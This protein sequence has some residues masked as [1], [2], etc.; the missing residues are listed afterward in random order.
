MGPCSSAD[1]VR[2]ARGLA[3]CA[4][5]GAS[6]DL[7]CARV[8]TP[9][10]TVPD[11]LRAPSDQVVLL[12]ANARG[13]QIYECK[14]AAGG[15]G[16]FGWAL[17]AP[18]ATLLDE[19]GEVIGKHYAGPTWEVRDGSRVVGEKVAQSDAPEAGAI[20]WLL[21][22]VREAEGNGLLSGAKSVQRVA[23]S[24]GKPPSDGCD[25]AHTTAEVRVP[26]TATY[27]FNGSR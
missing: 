25:A 26:Y 7:A 8:R 2:L 18:E 9:S 15:S 27:Y 5:L 11:S 14:A 17:K 13:V 12:K 16:T 10:P 22:R 24:G 6:A 1:R 21:L 19:R 20:P 3:L 23:T 4:A